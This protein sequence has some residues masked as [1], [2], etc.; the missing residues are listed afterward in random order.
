MR[1]I[2]GTLSVLLA[3]S[4][5]I[6]HGQAIGLASGLPSRPTSARSDT[7]R[8]LSAVGMRQV[9]L[10]L[11]PEF[12]RAT[13]Y[14]LVILFDSGGEIPKRLERGEYADM[15]MIPRSGI[16]RLAEAGRVEAG[17][18][19][20]LAR[21]VV[22]VAVRKGA[23]KPDISTPAAFKRA[24]L[25]AKAIACPDPALGGSSGLHIARM[26]EQLGIAD[27]LRSRLVLS[28]TPDQER[29][30]PGYLV[31]TGKAEIALH[32]MQELMAV[33]GIEVVGPLPDA[34][35]GTFVFS[36]AILSDAR[37]IEA[38]KALLAYLR[39]PEARAIIMAKG[40][41]SVDGIEKALGR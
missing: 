28:S 6:L 15:V 9:L 31:A 36:V 1:G 20:D 32:Q 27:T 13:G 19:T 26:F 8:V 12:E 18:A 25:D 34:L 7:V 39:Q 37:E 17:S 11:E 14:E 35:Q 5:I 30:M 3:I 29:T 22:G 24:M 4:A 16:E 40:M 23:R 33:P 41:L 21:S 2:R 38:A 10:A